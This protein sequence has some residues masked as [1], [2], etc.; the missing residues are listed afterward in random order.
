MSQHFFWGIFILGG[1]LVK[2]LPFWFELDAVRLRAAP[3]IVEWQI[4]VKC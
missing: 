4:W 1:R 2:Y 3:H